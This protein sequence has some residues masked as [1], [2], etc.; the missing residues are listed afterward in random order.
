MESTDLAPLSLPGQEGEWL[1]WVTGRGRTGL[2]DAGAQV[3]ALK[4]V[5]PGDPTI[6]QLWND[7]QIALSGVFGICSLMG[8]V[9]PEA[10][11]RDEAEELEIGASRF[12][13]D[14]HLDVAVHAQLSSLD[15][16]V[17]E[18]SARRVLERALLAFR[19]SGVDRDAETRDRVRELDRRESELS[20]EFSRG[21]RDGRRTTTVPAAALAGMPRDWV[22]EHPADEDGQVEI[23]TDYPDTVP[24]LTH[25]RDP[26]ARR[27]VAHSSLNIAWPENEPVLAELLGVREEKAACWGTPTGRATTPS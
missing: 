8:A 21:I 9:H 18:V 20:Q 19:R 4:E 5:P 2:A 22:A 13:T 17:L 26:G 10:E 3:A 23:S 6:L 16:T 15:A 14:L 24:F 11:V 27:A 7:A 25:A 1:D 12:A